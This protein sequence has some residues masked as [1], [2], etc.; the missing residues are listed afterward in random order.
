MITPNDI[1][2]HSEWPTRVGDRA[3]RNVRE[4]QSCTQAILA[5]FMEDLGIDDPML[6][7]SAGCSPR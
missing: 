5:A 3:E 7:R 1:P 2:T 6:L 4:H